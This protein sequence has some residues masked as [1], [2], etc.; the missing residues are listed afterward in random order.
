MKAFGSISSRMK[1]S[2]VCHDMAPAQRFAR[3]AAIGAVGGYLLKEGKQP[4]GV[5]V[6]DQSGAI[7]ILQI[8][9]VDGY[10]ED[11]AEGVDK[12]MPLLALDLLARVIARAVDALRPE[13]F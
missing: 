1:P 13:A 2:N 3:L 12:Q 9:R 10:G 11:R 8:G 7:A 4:A 5:A 6:Q